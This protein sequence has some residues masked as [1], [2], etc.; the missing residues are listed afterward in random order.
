MN[1]SVPA[2]HPVT[3]NLGTKVRRSWLLA[4]LYVALSA[5][6]AHAGDADTEREQLARIASEIERVQVMV[7]EAAQTAPTG[8]R[9]KFRY[10]WLLRDLGQLREGVTAHVDAPR[11]PRPVPP[12]RGDYRQ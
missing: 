7:S 8:E 10:D 4:V 3:V 2:Q 11:Q 1:T 9:V 12:L 5:S 6:S